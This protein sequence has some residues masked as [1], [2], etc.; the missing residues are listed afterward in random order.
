MS[1]HTGGLWLL[2]LYILQPDSVPVLPM[3]ATEAVLFSSA[4]TC[5]AI[6]LS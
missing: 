1:R 2:L 5:S 3:R 4:S 6:L